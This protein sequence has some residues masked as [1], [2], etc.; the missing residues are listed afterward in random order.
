[1]M[2]AARQGNV[3]QFDFSTMPSSRAETEKTSAALPA[4]WV[5]PAAL[6]A[7]AE[8]GSYGINRT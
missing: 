2:T 7:K 3:V 6:A 4:V 5:N 8:E 1:M